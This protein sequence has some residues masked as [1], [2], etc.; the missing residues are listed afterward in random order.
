ML[1]IAVS[2]GIARL[3]LNVEITRATQVETFKGSPLIKKLDT[4]WVIKNY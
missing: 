4:Y 3:F 1:A 2:L